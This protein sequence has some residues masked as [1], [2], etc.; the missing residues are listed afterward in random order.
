[1]HCPAGTEHIF[2]GAGAGPCVIVMAGSRAAHA[3]LYPVS[4]VAAR[5]GAS[6]TEETAVPKEACAGFDRGRLGPMPGGA[7][8]E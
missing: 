2:V 6:V 1:M 8:P 3:I 5:H 4:E 7:L